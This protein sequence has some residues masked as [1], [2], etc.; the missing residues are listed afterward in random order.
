MGRLRKKKGLNFAVASKK[1]PVVEIVTAVESAC[2]KLNKSDADD[3]R[4]SVNNI[5]KKTTQSEHTIQSIK[6][7]TTSL[8]RTPQRQKYQ[9]ITS[10]QGPLHSLTEYR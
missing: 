9:Y 1:I 5:F 4:S 8:T 6:G 7:R 2:L 10:R 3:L